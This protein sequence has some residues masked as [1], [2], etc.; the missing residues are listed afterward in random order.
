MVNETEKSV[1]EQKE[2]GR[3]MKGN[4]SLRREK[5]DGEMNEKR[6][7]S[8]KEAK[9]ERGRGDGKEER[10]KE[11][12]KQMKKR[13]KMR[14]TIITSAAQKYIRTPFPDVIA[15][16]VHPGPPAPIYTRPAPQ[17]YHLAR[18]SI[19]TFSAPAQTSQIKAPE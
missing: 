19:S 13:K 6:E 5:R 9:R 10:M 17:I 18:S 8:L 14:E 3:K 2:C 4:K 7:R 16:F 15:Y 11:S 12:E 1:H